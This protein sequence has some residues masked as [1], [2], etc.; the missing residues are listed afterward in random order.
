MTP[1]QFA[2]SLGFDQQTGYLWK[3]K[4]WLVLHDDGSVNVEASKA[5]LIA[6]RGTLG[7]LTQRQKSK[8]SG[9]SKGPHCETRNGF[10]NWRRING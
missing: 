7:P 1:R 8:R 4:G 6:E 5:R 2:V 9:W 3:T 10:N